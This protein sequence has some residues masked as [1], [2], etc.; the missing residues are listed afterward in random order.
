[1]IWS[2][3]YHPRSRGGKWQHRTMN[4][5]ESQTTKPRTSYDAD[6]WRSSSSCPSADWLGR[7]DDGESRKPGGNMRLDIICDGGIH[8]DPGCKGL[9]GISPCVFPTPAVPL[10]SVRWCKDAI[11][12]GGTSS[13]NPTSHQ[14]RVKMHFGMQALGL[15][16]NLP[17]KSCNE[18][19]VVSF[20]KDSN[21]SA[22]MSKANRRR[23][24]AQTSQ[25]T[26][27]TERS[28][29]VMITASVTARSPQCCV[30]TLTVAFKRNLGSKFT[31]IEDS[32]SLQRRMWVGA[33]WLFKPL[34][35]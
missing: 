3:S 25:G 24:V 34:A 13:L 26:L 14:V 5:H 7:D 21:Q 28:K 35:K 30:C 15:R 20:Q 11:Q 1:V 19:G 33:D 22:N 12:W 18:S 32:I 6:S 8:E 29:K 27:Y 10:S 16:T 17:T 4:I 31:K 9:P 23:M 2:Y